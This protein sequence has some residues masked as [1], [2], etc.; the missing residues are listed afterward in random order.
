MVEAQVR[1]H[2]LQKVQAHMLHVIAAIKA[3]L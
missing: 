3:V 2:A 1:E